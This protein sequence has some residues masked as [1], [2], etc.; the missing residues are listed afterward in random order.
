MPPKGDRRRGRGNPDHPFMAYAD[1]VH[2]VSTAQPRRASAATSVTDSV[3]TAH[4]SGQNT[5]T[6]E[7][8]QTGGMEN[9][10][11][12]ISN[13]GFS[14]TVTNIIMDSWRDSTKKQYGS[15]ITRWFKFSGDHD[16][17]PVSPSLAQACEYLVHLFNQGLGYSA[18][19][20]ARSALS[21]FILSK[22]GISFGQEPLVVRLMKGFFNRRPTMPRYSNTWNPDTVLDYLKNTCTSTLKQLAFK[23]LM[24]L[25]LAT[26]QRC[27]TLHL[28]DISLMNLTDN[29][30]ISLLINR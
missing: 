30:V 18:I 14:E 28:L 6:L 25:A 21:S 16:F 22:N 3:D 29:L 23:L 27:R 10:Q 24:L 5:P 7:I 13:Q 15:Y 11:T 12:L 20:T 4:R 9:I 2:T 19:N 17:N 1:L 8:T 26:A